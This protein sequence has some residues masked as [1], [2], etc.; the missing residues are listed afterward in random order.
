MTATYAPRPWPAP[1]SAHAPAAW[2]F[3]REVLLEGAAGP[4]R[5]LQWVL[6]RNCSI[7][8]RQLGRVYLSLCLLAAVVSA[9]FWWQGAPLISA[10]AGLEILAVGAALLAYARHAGDREV[11]TLTGRSLAVE[12]RLGGRVEQ[13]D[14]E[15]AWLTVEPAAGQG[16][17]VELKARGRTLCVGRFLRPE[18]RGAFAQELR[19]AVRRAGR[20][21]EENTTGSE[22]E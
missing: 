9:A 6:A 3:G 22:T 19:R 15:C 17:L 18:L 4:R 14:L 5:A 11:L 12:Q 2:R 20:R 16:S 21:P 13:A 7:T 1:A 10:F 8:P